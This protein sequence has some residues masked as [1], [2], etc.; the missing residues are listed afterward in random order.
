ME[1]AVSFFNRDTCKAG[2][3]AER[4]GAD[5]LFLAALLQPRAMGDSRNGVADARPVQAGRARAV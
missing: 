4:A 2:A 5:A 3:I 1:G